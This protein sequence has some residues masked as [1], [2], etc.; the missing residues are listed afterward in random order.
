MLTWYTIHE[1]WSTWLVVQYMNY[2]L[3][4]ILL[5]TSFALIFSKLIPVTTSDTTANSASAEKV[6]EPVLNP[7]KEG[8]ALV[9]KEAVKTDEQSV[10]DLSSS[11]QNEIDWQNSR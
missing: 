4:S 11:D 7:V 9:A 8:N 6:P 5:I 3:M 10:F 2:F 1:S